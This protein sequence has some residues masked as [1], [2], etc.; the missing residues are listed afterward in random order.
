MSNIAH[1]I[2]EMKRRQ[3]VHLSAS[4]CRQCNRF[5]ATRDGRIVCKSE[6]EVNYPFGFQAMLGSHR[7]IGQ[8][9]ADGSATVHGCGIPKGCPFSM[10]YLF[11]GEEDKQRRKE[12][13][14]TQKILDIIR[15]RR[16][17]K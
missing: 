14:Q 13:T 4:I 5:D 7:V 15:Q 1:I 10:E 3:A 16:I 6:D 11:N 8:I 12:M 17:K 9:S 2:T